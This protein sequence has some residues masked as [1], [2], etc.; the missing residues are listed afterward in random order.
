[1]S[2]GSSPGLFLEKDAGEPLH[3]PVGDDQLAALLGDEPPFLE[4]ALEPTLLRRLDL[5]VGVGL[6]PPLRLFP[7]L[8][9]APALRLRGSALLL[10]LVLDDALAV[11]DRTLDPTRQLFPLG[12]RQA[13]EGVPELGRPERTSVGRQERQRDRPVLGPGS[14]GPAA[15]AEQ[16][17]EPG[18]ESD[19][20][21]PGSGPVSRGGPAGGSRMRRERGARSGCRRGASWAVPASSPPSGRRAA[22]PRVR[23]CG[24][25]PPRPSGA[26]GE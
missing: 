1:M 2:P 17:P 15:A 26:R 8:L 10:G 20:T 24:G 6:G 19:G 4:L 12:G 18:S 5:L 22:A 11:L 14:G 21:R 13:R 3:E 16:A 9:E 25:R 23:R 7:L